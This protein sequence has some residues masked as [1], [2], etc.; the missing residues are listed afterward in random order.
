MKQPDSTKIA[1]EKGTKD[2]TG[3]VVPNQARFGPKYFLA[4]M[5]PDFKLKILT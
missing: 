4:F 3:H 2:I 1:F 5:I